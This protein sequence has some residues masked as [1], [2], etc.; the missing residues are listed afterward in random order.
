MQVRVQRFTGQRVTYR[1]RGASRNDVVDWY[2]LTPASRF[3]VIET[4]TSFPEGSAPA[5][6]WLYFALGES[7]AAKE[8][9]TQAETS[10]P[11]LIASLR[12]LAGRAVRARTND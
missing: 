11:A 3:A 1:K 12:A 7:G 6:G 5:V 2:E 9:W 4:A 10:S 8:L